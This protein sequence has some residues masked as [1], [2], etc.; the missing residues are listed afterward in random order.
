MRLNANAISTNIAVTALVAVLVLLLPW[1]DRRI[2]A[3]L[4]VNLHHGVSEN[5]H[6][7]FLLRVRQ[8]IL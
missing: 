4:G 2:C 3:K 1:L 5:P 6:A 7:D 8:G